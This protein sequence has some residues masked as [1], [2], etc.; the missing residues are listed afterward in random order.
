M[1]TWSI[2][3]HQCLP[4]K[5]SN[6]D[7]EAMLTEKRWPFFNFI[8]DSVVVAIF[9]LVKDK[10]NIYIYILFSL[11]YH[12]AEQSKLTKSHL[13]GLKLNESANFKNKL[14]RRKAANISFQATSRSHTIHGCISVRLCI[15]N[16]LM[17]ILVV[18]LC[19]I[20]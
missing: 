1:S 15:L 16:S 20:C 7:R 3:A 10:K 9:S 4:N 18:I 5:A 11:T 8:D 13:W 6:V 2:L 14:K 19:Y 12:I 17:N